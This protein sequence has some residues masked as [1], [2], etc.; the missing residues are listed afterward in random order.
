MSH[1]QAKR[2]RNSLKTNQAYQQASN[3]VSYIKT[4]VKN[5]VFKNKELNGKTYTTSTDI[6]DTS[7]KRGMYLQA[8]KSLV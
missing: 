5:L 7:T 1:K 8:K 2:V 4:N 3:V 6:V